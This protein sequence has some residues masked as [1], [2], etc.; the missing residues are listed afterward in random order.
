M[1][2]INTPIFVINLK[3][4]TDRKDRIKNILRSRK[5]NFNFIDAV[6]GNQLT[7]NEINSIYDKNMSLFRSKRELKPSEIGCALSHLSIY[8]RMLKDDI[9]EAIIL[10]D[11]II[12]NDNFERFSSSL[13]IFP[14]DWDLILLGHSDTPSG[15][16]D[17]CKIKVPLNNNIYAL[18]V[19]K[20]LVTVGGAY[21]YIINKSGA[22]KILNKAKKL[23][24]P[25][26]NYTGD[27]RIVNLYAVYPNTVRVNFNLESSIQNDRDEAINELRSVTYQTRK[28]LKRNNK[29]YKKISIL[30]KKRKERRKWTIRCMIRILFYKINTKI[31]QFK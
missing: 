13:N 10:E 16:T 15:L 21:G 18:S 11:D 19:A 8:K 17:L 1:C 26:D 31:S 28:R 20:P 29:I 25:I 27:Y 4:D 12:L 7:S 24:Q 9:E 23:Y 5:L 2:K 30:N 3:K 14:R 6:D 22:R